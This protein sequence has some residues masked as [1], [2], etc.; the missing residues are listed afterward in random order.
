VVVAALVPDDAEQHGGGDED[1][2]AGERH[3]QVPEVRFPTSFPRIL[4]VF[5]FANSEMAN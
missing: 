3:R 5:V 4:K 1:A 2:K